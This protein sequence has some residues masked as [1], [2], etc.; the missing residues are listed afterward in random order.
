[1]S[2]FDETVRLASFNDSGQLMIAGIMRALSDGE[3]KV[4]LISWILTSVSEA[5]DDRNE[6]SAM[7]EKAR[8]EVN[9][10]CS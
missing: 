8:A 1:M 5:P 6:L 3:T 10:P 2:K 7:I 4:D 9:L